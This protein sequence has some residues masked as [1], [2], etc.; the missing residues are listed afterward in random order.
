MPAHRAPA[1]D[2]AVGIGSAGVIDPRTGIVLSATDAITDWPGTRIAHGIAERLRKRGI[3]QLEP[4]QIHVENDV[5][6]YARGEAFTGAAA[7]AASALVIAVGTGV[8]GAVLLNGAA[9]WGA[10]RGR[11]DRARADDRC[12]E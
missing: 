8:G 3:A 5:N 9:R 4:E 12:G 1:G 2:L 7:G 10:Q 6:A 11:R